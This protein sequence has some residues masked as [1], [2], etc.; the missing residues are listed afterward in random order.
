MQFERP[1]KGLV[2]GREYSFRVKAVDKE[3][4]LVAD[5]E[6]ETTL[7]Q[8]VFTY[9]PPPPPEVQFVIKSV[10]TDFQ[11]NRLLIDLDVPDAGQV[12]SYE[13]FIVDVDTGAGIY[14]FEP[15]LFRSAQIEEQLPPAI[16]QLEETRSYRLTLF[17]STR[18]GRRL[19][20]EPY[21]FKAVPPPPPS[22]LTRILTVLQIPVVLGVIL[23]IVL[24][25]IGIVVYWSRPRRKEDLPPPMPR[26]PIDRTIMTDSPLVSG[27]PR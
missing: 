8:Q 12:N 18:D 21:E 6:G 7:A 24:S 22:L 19:Q 17:L 9:E 3:G 20:A 4:F 2:A 26:P 13:G 16:Q 10:Q 25:T 5:E 1:G 14:E 27:T 11:N 23:V 15:N